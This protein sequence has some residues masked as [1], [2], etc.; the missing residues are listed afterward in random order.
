[1]SIYIARGDDTLGPYH[2]EE[3]AELLRRG[4]LRAD[5]LA[6]RDG[7]A[8]WTPLSSLIALETPLPT[9]LQAGN[10][11]TEPR[12]RRAAGVGIL[13]G[14]AV[15]GAAG[16][17]LMV[18]F[19]PL[20]APSSHPVDRPP[21]V[22]ARP[23]AKPLP[24]STQ[25]PP[26]PAPVAVVPQTT[27]PPPVSLPS[28]SPEATRPVAAVQPPPLV[29]TPPPT[30][31]ATPPLRRECHLAGT[32]S[33]GVPGGEPTHFPG[34]RV[35]AYTLDAL[36]PL[37]AEKNAYVQGELARLAPQV[38][39]AG[40]EKKRRAALAKDA[41][42]AYLDSPAS[43]PLRSSLHFAAGQAK[44]DVGTAAADYQYLLDE[45]DDALDGDF[46]F[47]DLP[48]PTVEA[49]TD[50][51]GKFALDLPSGG[52]YVLAVRIHQ[53]GLGDTRTHYWLVKIALEDGSQRSL[54]LTRDNVASAG[55][56]DS[57]IHTAY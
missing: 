39:A 57:L 3:A 8:A 29:E 2:P 28:A 18:R 33:L 26:T 16:G 1:M 6:A 4:Q 44:A 52:P 55:S 49:Q 54:P 13:V 32:V 25:R 12:A 19:W 5:D 7:D 9:K 31:A 46:Y 10:V 24:V 48:K 51:A 14:F 11:S 53:T 17:A 40:E 37:L 43:D 35:A 38:Q 15:L 30:A 41:Q 45:H 56:E 36:L 23:S 27:P 22:L 50:A 21:A 20:R 34:V 47:R 42:Q